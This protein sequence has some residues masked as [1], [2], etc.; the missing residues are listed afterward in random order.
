MVYGGAPIVGGV[1]GARKAGV[2]AGYAAWGE[3][4]AGDS[5]TLYL[6]Y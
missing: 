5:T 6:V 2:L 4:D 1:D 3:F